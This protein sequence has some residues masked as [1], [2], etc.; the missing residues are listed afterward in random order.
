[1]RVGFCRTAVLLQLAITPAF[2]PQSRSAWYR[3]HPHPCR[4]P[5][6]RRRQ[7]LEAGYQ[8][9]A[10]CQP[11]SQELLL[12]PHTSGPRSTRW[13]GW[14]LIVWIRGTLRLRWWILLQL[15]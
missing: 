11:I 8:P 12:L 9:A 4:T 5:G 6:F 1:M 3:F 13:A 7:E 15:I 2:I 10:V 14:T